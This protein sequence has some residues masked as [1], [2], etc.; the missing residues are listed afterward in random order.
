MKNIK[1]AFL[2]DIFEVDI[3][4][5]YY[6]DSEGNKYVETYSLLDVRDV[7]DQSHEDEIRFN[8]IIDL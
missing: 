4:Y 6:R 2:E 7:E 3:L 8:L 1:V 5:R